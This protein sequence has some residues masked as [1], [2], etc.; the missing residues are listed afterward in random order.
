[1]SIIGHIR[2]IGDHHAS[3]HHGAHLYVTD[4]AATNPDMVEVGNAEQLVARGEAEWISRSRGP[5]PETEEQQ[6]RR[7]NL[8]QQTLLTKHFYQHRDMINRHQA[9]NAAMRRKAADDVA[10]VSSLA[11]ALK[12]AQGVANGHT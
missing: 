9:E 7:H 11:A 5:R 6:A 3:H 2:L 1:M 4:T 10:V 8:E 12:T